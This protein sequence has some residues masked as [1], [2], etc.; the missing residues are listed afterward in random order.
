MAQEYI[1]SEKELCDL[2]RPAMDYED[3]NI[4]PKYYVKPAE[5]NVAALVG[6]IIGGLVSRLFAY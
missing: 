2:Y 5:L 6:G 4:C 3:K 1:L